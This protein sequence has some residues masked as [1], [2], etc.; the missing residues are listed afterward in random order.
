MAIL[1]GMR[2]IVG[3]AVAG[4]V[5]AGIAF[6]G[7]IPA[8][9]AA[10][11]LLHATAL[12]VFTG[13]LVAVAACW[14]VV[15]ALRSP[16]A[17]PGVWTFAGIAGATA[18]C[19]IA[20][21]VATGAGR[22][23]QTTAADSGDT[24]RVV[25]ANLLAGNT[26]Y[27]A[28]FRRAPHADV[29]ALAE[30]EPDM[31]RKQLAVY[32][33]TDRFRTIVSDDSNAAPTILLVRTRLRPVAVTGGD[34]PFAAAAATSTAGRIVAVH[35]AAPVARRPWQSTWQS[36]VRAAA[37]QCGSDA[38]VA[39]D[40]NAVW[41]QL[42]PMTSCGDAATTLHKGAAGSWRMGWPT[43]LGSRIDHQ[44]YDTARYSP[45]SFE[46]FDLPGSDH[47]GTDVVYRTVGGRGGN[48]ATHGDSRTTGRA[49]SGGEV[50][51]S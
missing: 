27:R 7:R 36:T 38:L 43:W 42:Q 17:R 35:T 48:N 25:Q 16:T 1:I 33:L 8:L 28:V 37:A 29:I 11:G 15:V 18:I 49:T 50:R 20:A 24:I 26:N 6:G 12:P 39:G 32:H 10:S 30:A 3:G 51:G 13:I 9:A 45:L 44:L 47:R 21:Q 34:V 31:V 4:L 23:A 19:L 5:V 22:K 41:P 40:F 2:G 46:L 14:A